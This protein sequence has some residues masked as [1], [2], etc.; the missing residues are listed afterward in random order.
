MYITFLKVIIKSGSKLGK[1]FEKTLD[2]N[3]FFD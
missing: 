3:M 2:F 1:G